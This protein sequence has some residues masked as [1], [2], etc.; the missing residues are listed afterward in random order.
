MCKSCERL[1]KNITE[2]QSELNDAHMQIGGM[3]YRLEQAEKNCKLA[4]D[5]LHR[6]HAEIAMLDARIKKGHN[7]D[8]SA[9]C[10]LSMII[11]E[12]MARDGLKVKERH[13]RALHEVAL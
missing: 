8:K 2:Y 3:R 4:A 7:A 10:E 12:A 9:L 11:A 13:L 1:T 5:L 6:A